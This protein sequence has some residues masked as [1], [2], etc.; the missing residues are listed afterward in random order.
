MQTIIV[1]DLTRFKKGNPNVCI[2]G[3]DIITS[4]CIRPVP[5]L[6]SVECKQKKILPGTIISGVFTPVAI[7]KKPHTED[8][9]HNCDLKI[10]GSCSAAGFKKILNDTLIRSIQEG[11]GTNQKSLPADYDGDRSIITI[12]IN[13]QDFRLVVDSKNPG[14]IRAIFT[15]HLN[16][17]YRFLPIT[18]LGYYDY[19]MDKNGIGELHLINDFIHSQDELFLRVGLGRPP[20]MDQYWMQINGIYTFPKY[21]DILRSYE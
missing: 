21:I 20:Y 9:G 2:A 14:R 3:I 7:T 19:A 5:Y 17:S 8:R 1:T 15:D 10:E 16:N 13:P 12:Q 11:Y 4:E 18:D 6:T